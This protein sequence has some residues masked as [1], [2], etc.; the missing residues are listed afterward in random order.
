MANPKVIRV[1]SETA[2]ALTFEFTLRILRGIYD[3]L[4]DDLPTEERLKLHDLLIDE[5]YLLFILTTRRGGWSLF[6]NPE[7]SLRT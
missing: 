7:R 2:D 5:T 3:A 1:A 6:S 4:S